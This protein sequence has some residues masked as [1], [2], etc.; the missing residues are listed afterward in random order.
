MGHWVSPKHLS[1]SN[2]IPQVSPAAAEDLG[3]YSLFPIPCTFTPTRRPAL[4]HAVGKVKP[5]SPWELKG[6]HDDTPAFQPDGDL[7]SRKVWE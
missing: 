1:P 3:F 2:R 6:G 5:P 7:R 4:P